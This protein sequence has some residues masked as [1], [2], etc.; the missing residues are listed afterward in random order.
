VP[1]L[2]IAGSI[3]YGDGDAICALHESGIDAVLSLCSGPMTLEQAQAQSET[4]LQR[5]AEQAVRAFLSGR[6]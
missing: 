6:G 4:L 5:A 1:C 2:A 3:G